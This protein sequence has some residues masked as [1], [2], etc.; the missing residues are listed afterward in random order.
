M[1]VGLFDWELAGDDHRD[2][3]ERLFGSEMPEIQYV[4][5]EQALVYES[6]RLSRIVGDNRLDFAVYDS[7][8]FACDGPPESAE[9]AGRYFRAVRQIGIGS[10][11][12]AHITK[13]D[14][15]DQK[16]FGS[17]FWHN[18]AR[19]TYY[20][21]LSDQSPDG[22]TLSLGLFNRKSNLGGLRQPTGFL[23]NF[24]DDRTY[25]QK[26]NPVDIPDLAE[27]M[28]LRQRMNHALRGGAIP[29]DQLANML[30]ARPDTL[31]RTVRRHSK[32]FTI[33]EGGQIALAK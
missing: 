25:F 31:S 16:P 23:V 12:I 28:T 5:C 19:S 1:R 10:L 24:T 30:D 4:R 11:H 6:D 15:G 17:V 33:I 22:R 14:G 7:I 3:L 9:V 26:A 8:A 32:Q 21:Q 29:L 13:S 2:R 20:I 27:K 18:G